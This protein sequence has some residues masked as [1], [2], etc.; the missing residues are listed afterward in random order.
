M[1]TQTTIALATRVEYPI[2]EQDI[3]AAA[4]QYA[5][6]T[7][8]T[9]DR[10]EEGRKAIAHLRST[11][12]AIE[13]R[14]VEL[15][16]GALEY[17]R[18][19]DAMAKRLTALIADVEEPLKAKKKAIDDE[20]ERAKREAER[21]ELL[22]LEAKLRVEREAAEATARAEREAEE[23]RLAAERVR[24]AELEAVQRAAREK[25][26]AERAELDRRQRDIEQAERER[27]A[28]VAAEED[29]R[30]AVERDRLA[31]QEAA[32][33]AAAETARREALRPDI[34]KIHAYGV[35]VRVLVGRSPE[36]ATEE[37]AKALAWATGRL[38]AIASALDAY[39]GKAA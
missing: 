29:A 31:E 2:T 18:K 5:A 14:R 6:L 38:A 1:E 25:L 23:A 39:P 9:P 4:A 17:G 3:T 7:F 28:K 34:E 19:V 8:D 21:V 15:K 32:G 27:A 24:L 10:Y 16:A 22:V 33:R 13:E 35:A 36:M 20:K 11:R 37:G 26:E 30:A 12:T